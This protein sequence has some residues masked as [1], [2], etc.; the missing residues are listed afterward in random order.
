M[1]ILKHSGLLSAAAL[2]TLGLFTQVFPNTP[3]LERVGFM[4]GQGGSSSEVRSRVVRLVFEGWDKF[5]SQWAAFVDVVE[6][7]GYNSEAPARSCEQ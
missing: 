7:I 2:R 1:K 5:E 6:K 4:G 3:L